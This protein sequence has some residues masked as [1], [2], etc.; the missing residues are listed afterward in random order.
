MY[1]LEN[2]YWWYRG[3]HELVEKH[4][5]VHA[6]RAA[7]P[8]QMLDAGC[9]TGRM[10]EIAR[11]YGKVE[12]LDFS[13]E[14]L[15]FCA[16]RGLHS[17]SCQDLTAWIPPPEKYDGIVCL[18]VLC[19]RS[20]KDEVAVYRKF[21]TALQPEGVLILNLPAFE[22]LRRKHDRAVHSRK[23]YTKHR[24][25]GPL[26][27]AGFR[28]VYASYRLPFLFVLMLIKKAVEHRSGNEKI[29]SDLK[30]LSPWL[31]AFFLAL[32]RVENALL[33]SGITLPVGSSLFIVAKKSG[34]RCVP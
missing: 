7:H 5:R 27:A 21:L 33:F 25:V 29:Q 23:R 2:T 34:I 15:K 4:L 9:G 20:I 24:T 26:A 6:R 10:M 3:L 28:I 18:D 1:S 31:N 14:A 17:Y 11:R 8:L 19:H 30:P 16:V 13:P 32:H 12:G 22:L